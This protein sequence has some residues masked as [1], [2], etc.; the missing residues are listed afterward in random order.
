MINRPFT[1]MLVSAALLVVLSTPALSFA[2][3]NARMY[4]KGLPFQ[5]ADLPPRSRLRRGLEGL[6]P[7]AQQRALKNLKEFA[8]PEAD[9][10]LLEV[11]TDG[12]VF[13]IDNF[14][15]T[16]P[17]ATGSNE[18]QIAVILPAIDVFKLHS[19][20]G[21]GRVVFL[22]FD[23]HAI[24]GTAWNANSGVTTYVAKPFSID[25]DF[26]TFNTEERNA[27]H[28]TWHRIA[29][30]FSPFD[31]DVTTQ[32]P[33]SFGPTVA[34]VLFTPNTDANNVPMP[35]NTSGGIAYVDVWGRADFATS[36]QPALVYSDNQ[37]N[38]APYMAEAGSHEF[39]HNLS[40]AHD[41]VVDGNANPL[42]PGST[43]YFCGLG[44][45][46]VSWGPIMGVG[47]Y[48]NV[49]QWSEGNYPS[50]NNVAQDDMAILSAKLSARTDDHANSAATAT[51]LTVDATG[52]IV[53]TTPQ[54][55]P[56]NTVTANKG[57]IGSQS[58]IDFYAFDAGAGPFSVTVT[59]AWAAFP[60]PGG[61]GANLD[62]NA[63]LYAANGTTVLLN[64]DS[65]NDT[66]AALSG[67]LAAGRYFLAVTAVGNAVTPYSAYN[68]RGQYFIA[69]SLVVPALADTAP[70][71]PSPMSF[72]SPPAALSAS[73]INM[74]ATTASDPSGPVQ[75]RFQCLAGG[76]GCLSS[77]WQTSTSYAATG[78]V[79]STTY[80]FAVQARDGLGNV[81][82]SSSSFQATTQS[83]APPTAPS[84]LAGT[85]LRNRRISLTWFENANSESAIVLER[86]VNGTTYTTRVTLVANANS[87]LDS[88]LTAGT[89][90][91]YRVKATNASGSSPYSNVAGPITASR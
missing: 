50:A 13:Y 76:T 31:I 58:D 18:V 6:P 35:F 68:S 61:R 7:Q 5:I 21:A 16:A 55:D 20:P 79:A 78:L 56:G 52:V 91:Y 84:N 66:M 88:G 57:I 29:E 27:V 10:H 82:A 42:C 8:F 40:L 36:Y 38:H 4:G 60:R 12:G 1:A 59:P 39:G 83:L 28:E 44:S 46:L 49:T 47:Y 67:N 9:T 63:T 53:S 51:V 70:P 33:A 54:N 77:A 62:I 69:G 85:A 71:T 86:S 48:T 45:G 19:K 74:T 23:G 80:S 37:L 26:S 15:P 73:Q 32:Q 11:D 65:I 14:V 43:A 3:A 2:A 24:S 64:N 34:R 89:R 75:Y 81:T 17:P 72:A 87:F 30:D 90:Y 22:D 41:G 25:A